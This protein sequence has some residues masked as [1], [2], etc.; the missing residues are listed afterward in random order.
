MVISNKPFPHPDH[1]L[2]LL[3][4]D[5]VPGREKENSGR[6]ND[7]FKITE[8]VGKEARN[9]AKLL[10]LSERFLS[11]YT[12]CTSSSLPPNAVSFLF[13]SSLTANLKRALR[14]AHNAQ[15]SFLTNTLMA[16]HCLL[17]AISS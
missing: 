7:L 8:Q 1:Y 9:G 16:Q 6:G 14:I 5:Q 2:W 10:C 13:F 15:L 3:L 17:A 4:P 11:C 12:L